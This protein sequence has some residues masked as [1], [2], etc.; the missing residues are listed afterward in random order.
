MNRTE[1]ILREHNRT[2]R[3]N[4]VPERTP[5][6][7][8]IPI[9]ELFRRLSADASHLVQQ[10]VALARTELQE[11]LESVRKAAVVFAVAALVALPGLLALT[12]FLVVI[13]ANAI[14]SWAIATLVVGVALLAISGLMVQRGRAA[15]SRR[16][17]SL[18]DTRASLARDAAW[19]KEEVRA[20]K[21][22]LTA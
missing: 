19:G 10:E 20:F 22:E 18:P 3:T 15:L 14:G 7:D 8:D 4:G 5:A 21:E 17:V 16:N 2:G 11:A 12:A 13:L 6:T 1:T 9:G